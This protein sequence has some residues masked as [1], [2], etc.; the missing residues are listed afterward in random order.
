MKKQK[1]IAWEINYQNKKVDIIEARTP[2]G[3]MKIFCYQ[4]G[5]PNPPINRNT[6][7]WKNVSVLP[8][9]GY[10]V[11]KNVKSMFLESKR[12]KVDLK[13]E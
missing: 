6:G 8:V 10:S 2:E 5:L 9:N 7:G 11:E 13:N 1:K 3:A 4:N 12:K